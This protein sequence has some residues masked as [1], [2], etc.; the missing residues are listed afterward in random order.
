LPGSLLA[1]L[2]TLYQQS[3]IGTA[4]ASECI[5]LIGYGQDPA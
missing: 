4:V 5:V 2:A 3:D 1:T